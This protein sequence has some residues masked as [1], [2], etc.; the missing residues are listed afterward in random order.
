MAL[1]TQKL[2]INIILLNVIISAITMAYAATT[3][4]DEDAVTTIKKQADQIGRPIDDNAYT[5]YNEDSSGGGAGTTEYETSWGNP[6]VLGGGVW[7]TLATGLIPFAA[8]ITIMTNTAE[9]IVMYT[10][11]FIRILLNAVL[12]FELFLIIK[13]KKV[14]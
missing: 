13:N 9:R 4:T 12:G 1:S 5:M 8:E 14:S 6:Y 3:F 7:G 2:I 10:I 11:M